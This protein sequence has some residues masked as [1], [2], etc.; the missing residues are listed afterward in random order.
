MDKRTKAV[1]T[2]FIDNESNPN[3]WLKEN[4]TEYGFEI[5]TMNLKKGEY[6]WGVAIIDT[7]NNNESGINISVKGTIISGWVPLFKVTVK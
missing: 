6:I 2:L 7:S 5:Q 1:Q 3:D 4:A